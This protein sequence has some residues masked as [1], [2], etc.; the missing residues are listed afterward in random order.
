M[1]NNKNFTP[2]PMSIIGRACK[3]DKHYR[4]YK[5]TKEFVLVE[6]DMA[7][8]AIEKSGIAQPYKVEHV[9][10]EIEGIKS[11]NELISQEPESPPATTENLSDDNSNPSIP[12]G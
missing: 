10:Y 4:V 3:N 1:S 5:D 7:Y 11:P 6:A 9:L 12:N 8:E 2:L